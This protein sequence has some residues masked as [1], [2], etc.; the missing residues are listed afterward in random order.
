MA[1]HNGSE[2]DARCHATRRDGERCGSTIVLPSGF[3]AM[4]DP[5]RRDENAAARSKG[6]KHS[7][8]VV[9]LRGLLP[10]RLIPVFERLETALEEVHSGDLDPRAATAMA[11]LG[12]AL[13]AV[14]Q[15]GELEERLRNVEQWQTEQEIQV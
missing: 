12:R 9:R 6:G 15:A 13:V 8:T 14:L 10:P 5:A 3:C 2:R 1:K 11:S 7:A 4:H